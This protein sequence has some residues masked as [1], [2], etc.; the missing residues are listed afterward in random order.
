[1]VLGGRW[2]CPTAKLRM[3]APS[4]ALQLWY[5]DVSAEEMAETPTAAKPAGEDTCGERCG[6]LTKTPFN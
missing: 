1:M 2:L 6:E 4:L 3:C 5:A